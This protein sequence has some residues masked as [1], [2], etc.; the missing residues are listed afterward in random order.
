M[1]SG[2]SATVRR[3]CASFGLAA[4]P[5]AS[6]MP[7]SRG[8][9]A[10][11]WRLDT[12]QDRYAVK[13]T[14]WAPDDEAIRR[15]VAV[16]AHLGAAGIRLPRILPGASGRFMVPLADAGGWLRLYEW[17]DGAPADLADPAIA[18][19][20]GGLLGRLHAHALPS[21]GPP[22]PWYETVPA[23]DDWDL[24][25]ASARQQGAPWGQ[26][27]AGR[28]GPLRDL[29]GLVT[30]PAKAGLVTCHQDLHPGNVLVDAAGSLVALDWDDAGPAAP[31]A[32][33]PGS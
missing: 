4:M 10:R 13:K 23:P 11:I 5:Q 7:V 27:L 24:L 19:L 9:M 32:S 20:I 2:D 31:A 30:P 22:D 15:E 21:S 14:S 18:G 1:L 17:I 25:A 29:A 6:I 8:A 28:A 16:T 26:E 3:I 33:S 12:G